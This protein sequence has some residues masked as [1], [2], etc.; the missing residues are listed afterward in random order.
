MS[1]SVNGAT[2]QTAKNLPA[3]WE[4]QVPSLRR[5]DPPGGGMATHSSILHGESHGQRSPGGLYSPWGL[6]ESDTTER[7][8]LSPFTWKKHLTALRQ[9]GIWD[10]SLQCLH[11]DKGLSQQQNIKKPQGAE[12]NRGHTRQIL[13]KR[14]RE[15]PLPLLKSQKQKQDVGGCP[16]AQ[17]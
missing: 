11:P 6:K 2:A 15:V 7:L 8:T 5:D 13:G 3:V 9:T 4:A 16:E 1:Q 14:P 10:T 12:D 17:W